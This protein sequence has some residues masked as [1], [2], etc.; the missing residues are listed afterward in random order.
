MNNGPWNR[1]HLSSVI[2]FINTIRKIYLPAKLLSYAQ[3]SEKYKLKSG[4][5]QAAKFYL[6]P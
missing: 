3:M 5:L 2:F 4:E 6:K 1:W